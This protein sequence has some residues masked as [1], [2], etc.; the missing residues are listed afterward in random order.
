MTGKESH[1]YSNVH[2]R[3]N[4]IYDVIIP[5]GKEEGDFGWF[6]CSK[7]ASYFLYLISLSLT[8]FNVRY[9]FSSTLIHTQ[10]FTC[11]SMPYLCRTAQLSTHTEWLCL[12]PPFPR[13]RLA[14]SAIVTNYVYY[15]LGMGCMSKYIYVLAKTTVFFS[16]LSLNVINHFLC[17]IL[18]NTTITIVLYICSTF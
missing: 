9:Y 12:P 11:A 1:E 5:E 3:N 18:V 15:I 4:W 2:S 16:P 8:N 17:T 10:H 7:C 6:Y 13:C 14:A